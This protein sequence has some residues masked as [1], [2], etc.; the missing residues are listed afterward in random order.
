MSEER[1]SL[2][3]GLPEDHELLLP[4]AWKDHPLSKKTQKLVKRVRNR[5]LETGREA[6]AIF[7]ASG[8]GK[9]TFI[10]EVDPAIHVRFGDVMK[11]LA[12]KF[13]MVPHNREYYE[14]NRSA[15]FEKLYN[16]KE[17]LDAWIALDIIRQYNPFIFIEISLENLLDSLRHDKTRAPVI[18]SGMRTEAGLEITSAIVTQDKNFIRVERPGQPIPDNATLDELCARYP[19]K[20][21]VY[22]EGAEALIVALGKDVIK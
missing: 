17:P 9:D 4:C 16:G 13:N 11:D 18:F 15:R 5:C 21:I 3:L 8:A 19:A 22:N 1:V 14:K 12:F 6:Y 7:G 2:G 20:T 10:R